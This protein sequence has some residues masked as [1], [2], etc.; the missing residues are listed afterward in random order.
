[1]VGASYT[2]NPRPESSSFVEVS[3][4]IYEMIPVEQNRDPLQPFDRAN[5]FEAHETRL[6]LSFVPF[7]LSLG[8]IARSTPSR[9]L[10]LNVI[11]YN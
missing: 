9:K 5:R 10:H 6:P 11:L 1:M 8:K 4:E 3:I 7:V 2:D